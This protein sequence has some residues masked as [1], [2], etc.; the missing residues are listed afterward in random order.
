MKGGFYTEIQVDIATVYMQLTVGK[1]NVMAT[2][3]LA[4]P[5][6]SALTR[7]ISNSREKISNEKNGEEEPQLMKEP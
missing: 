2:R 6:L 5:V 1:G 3:D 4:K 7:V